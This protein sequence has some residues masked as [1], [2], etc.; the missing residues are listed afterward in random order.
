MIVRSCCS[1]TGG[2]STSTASGM[3]N[4]RATGATGSEQHSAGFGRKRFGQ[5]PLAV[6]ALLGCPLLRCQEALTALAGHAAPA[7]VGAVVGRQ[8]GIEDVQSDVSDAVP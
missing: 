3:V 6:D 4:V 5:L 8:A 7:R 2:V 1:V